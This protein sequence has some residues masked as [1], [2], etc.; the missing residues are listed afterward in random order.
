MIIKFRA[1]ILNGDWELA[2]SLL[3]D[4]PFISPFNHLDVRFLIRQQKFLELLE[5]SQ[6]MQALHVL[7]NEITP[8]GQNTERLHLLASL[9][10]CTS[11]EDVMQQASWDGAEGASREILLSE[12]QRYIDPTAM[13]PKHRLLELIN[14]ALEWQKRSCL[15]HNPK[16]DMEFSLFS[17]HMCDK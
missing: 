5:Q 3:I 4:I 6:V 1:S 15:Y 16:Q 11:I 14:Q 8:L 17:D 10:L 9:V 7:R 13:I 12:I 2:E